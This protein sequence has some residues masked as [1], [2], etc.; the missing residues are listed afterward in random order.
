RLGDRVDRRRLIQVSMAAATIMATCVAFAGEAHVTLIAISFLFVTL[1]F[2]MQWSQSVTIVL[3]Q[4]YLPTRIGTAS[5][6]TLGLAIS[7]G[8]FAMPFLGKLADA[9][10][11]VPVM[12]TIGALALASMVTAFFLPAVSKPD[13][14]HR[15]G[16]VIDDESRRVADRLRADPA[17]MA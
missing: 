2:L 10:G 12:F 3:G 6:V 5:G 11:L 16:R 17:P 4:E 9:H 14:D 8:G 1:A 7:M 13:D 15:S